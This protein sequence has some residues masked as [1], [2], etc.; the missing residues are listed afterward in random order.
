MTLRSVC[1]VLFCAAVLV[2]L[3]PLA[4]SASP[5]PAPAPAA[6]VQSAAQ[7]TVPV[8]HVDP[9]LGGD[10]SSRAPVVRFCRDWGQCQQ[11]I[12][13]GEP[14]DTAIGCVCGFGGASG[15]VCGRF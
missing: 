14:C 6:A 5:V 4:A 11:Q 12:P 2:L 1:L 8:L 10:L 3:L 13:P 15:W 7:A 9:L